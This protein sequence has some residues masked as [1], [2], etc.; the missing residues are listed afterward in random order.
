MTIKIADV[1]LDGIDNGL[2]GVV[3]LPANY[4]EKKPYNYYSSTLSFHKFA[5]N[6]LEINFLNEPKILL[7][8]KSNDWFGPVL[9][10][11]SFAYTANPEIIAIVC[12]VIANYVTDFFKGT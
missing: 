8:Q 12:S 4:L 10:I 11:S 3:I 2:T 6:K 1:N 7:E 5:K 9:F